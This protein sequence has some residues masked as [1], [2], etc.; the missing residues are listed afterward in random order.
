[1]G[2]ALRQEM[3]QASLIPIYILIPLKILV[4]GKVKGGEGFREKVSR[5]TTSS[6]RCFFSTDWFSEHDSFLPT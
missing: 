1:M 5:D 2:E 3:S 6:R 4:C